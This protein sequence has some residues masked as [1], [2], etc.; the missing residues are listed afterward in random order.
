MTMNRVLSHDLRLGACCAICQVWLALLC[1]ASLSCLSVFLCVYPFH[2]RAD[3]LTS[4][5]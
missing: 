3:G 1:F 5:E 2:S 4:C